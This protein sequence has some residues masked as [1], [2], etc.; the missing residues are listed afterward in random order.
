M[1]LVAHTHMHTQILN[2]HC[3]HRHSGKLKRF[4][5]P[6][7]S[8]GNIITERINRAIAQSEQKEEETQRG[9][10][11]YIARADWGRGGVKGKGREKQQKQMKV[12]GKNKQKSK[13]KSV[14][15]EGVRPGHRGI[16]GVRSWQRCWRQA[17]QKEARYKVTRTD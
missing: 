10:E 4:S 16:R 6:W 3:T 8:L 7:L 1:P 14:S 9:I 2:T 11:E 15:L 13:Q 12:K 5:A 17:G